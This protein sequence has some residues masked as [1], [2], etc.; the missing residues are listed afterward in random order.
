MALHTGEVMEALLVS[1]YKK[2]VE[3]SYHLSNNSMKGKI[4]GSKRVND[5]IRLRELAEI[6][7]VVLATLHHG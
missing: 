7:Y 3:W 2:L 1:S 4:G 6:N 5:T